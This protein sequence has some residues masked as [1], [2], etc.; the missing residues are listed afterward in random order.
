MTDFAEEDV[1][2]MAE[3]IIDDPLRYLDGDYTPE[4]YCSYCDANL[5]GYDKGPDDFKHE[6]TC[7]VLIAQ[8]ILTRR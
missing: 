2:K 8:D 7:P 5:I 6:V 1:I 4:W 3:A